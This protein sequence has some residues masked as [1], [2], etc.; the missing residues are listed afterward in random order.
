VASLIKERMKTLGESVEL[1]RF[2]F[3]D[4]EPNEKAAALI[5]R[6]GPDHLKE[7]ASRLE[8]VEE[9]SSEEI[10]R[11]LETMASDLGQSKTKAWQPIR[12][13]VTGSNVSPPLPESIALLGRER[14]IERLRRSASP[15]RSH[16]DDG[17]R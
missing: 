9:W 7:A 6:A 2:L 11:V 13:A 14:T 16:V 10:T 1:L 3:A 12:A 17:P 5:G 15:A 8:A 4:V